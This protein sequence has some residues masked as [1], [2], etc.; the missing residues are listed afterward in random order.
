MRRFSGASKCLKLLQFFNFNL[1]ISISVQLAKL[2]SRQVGNLWH[3]CCSEPEAVCLATL[4]C[5][6]LDKK[7]LP[8]GSLFLK[9]TLTRSI[10]AQRP[11]GL[12]LDHPRL[13][14]VL[15]L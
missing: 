2:S 4:C 1:V 9:Q 7:R 5:H 13:E 12:I 3:F 10:P 11:T 14:E 8:I 6:P 15:L